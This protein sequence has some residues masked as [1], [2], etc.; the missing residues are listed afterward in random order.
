MVSGSLL[1]IG[2]SHQTGV[3][4]S[5]SFVTLGLAVVGLV[6]VDSVEN[7]L[8]EFE[9]LQRIVITLEF[10]IGEATGNSELLAFLAA[11]I[12]EG[13]RDISAPFDGSESILESQE[14]S[15]VPQREEDIAVVAV[16]SPVLSIS[17]S[18]TSERLAVESSDLE[19]GILVVPLLILDSLPCLHELSEG[20]LVTGVILLLKIDDVLTETKGTSSF[21]CK[22]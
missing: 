21:F 10:V 6:T 7:L 22:L 11:L 4:V 12:P 14:I 2:S 13:K 18:S 17:P 1:V 5:H 3:G 20:F 16:S 9:G 8:W 19:E 15:S